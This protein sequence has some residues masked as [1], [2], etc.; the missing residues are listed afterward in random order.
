MEPQRGKAAGTKGPGTVSTGPRRIA[1]LA[2]RYPEG[3]LT[4]LAHHMTPDLLKEAFR[5]TRKKSAP[6]IDGTTWSEYEKDLESNLRSLHE[7]AKSGEYR[8]PAVRRVHIPK[9]NGNET[10]PIGIPTIEDKVLQRV[11]VMLMEPIYEREFRDCSCGFRPG[12]S[13]HQALETLWKQVMD[14]GGCWLVEVDIRKFFDTLDHAHLRELVQRRVR[15]GVLTRLIGKWLKAG[16]M[17]EEIVT[18]PESGTPQGGVISPLLANIYLHYVLDVWFE[19]EI[20]SRLGGKAFLIRYADD[21]VMGFE[22]EEDARRVLAVLPKR[23]AKYGLAIHPDKTRLIDFRPPGKGSAG[24]FDLLG[25]NHY[26]G[27]SRKGR[28]VVKRKTAKS[29]LRRAIMALFIWFRKV[30]HW[31]VKEQYAALV[32]K[33]KGHYAY[34]GITHN[35]RS[36]EH[37]RRKAERLWR[38]WLNRR[39][40]NRH[41]PWARFKNLLVKYPLPAARIVHSA[42]RQ[43]VKP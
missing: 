10:R 40:Q 19:D 36:L 39:S 21:F 6:G 13:A 5:R 38:Y 35:M 24:N 31:R 9:G 18:Y 4:T 17:E 22:R 20:K 28:M 41:V 32:R 37:F 11:T 7:R 16:V 42:V 25:F 8:A 26:W 30:R 43:A 23:F 15:D 14:M 27:K 2:A 34:Y 12:R 1:E 29:R 33:I 3:A